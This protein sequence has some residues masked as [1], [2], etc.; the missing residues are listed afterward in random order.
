MTTTQIYLPPPTRD[1]ALALLDEQR[2]KESRH[3]EQGERLAVARGRFIRLARRYSVPWVDIA[4]TLGVSVWAARRA[5]R[6]GR[7]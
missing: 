4:H 2:H 1:I 5:A 7:G 6:K 3:G